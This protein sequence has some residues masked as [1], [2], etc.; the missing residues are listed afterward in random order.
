MLPLPDGDPAFGLVDDVPARGES[1][2]PVRGRDTDP[3]GEVVDGEVPRAVNGAGAH[4]VEP[5]ASLVEDAT[6]LALGEGHVRLV[7]ELEDRPPLVVVAD[8]ALEGHEAAGRGRLEGAVAG[9]GVDGLAGDPEH[10]NPPTS[11]R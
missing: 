4:D 1:G 9:C 3:H 11:V 2:V 7:L 5:L 6:P 8:P 10:L